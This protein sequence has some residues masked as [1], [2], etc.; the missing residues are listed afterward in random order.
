[1][2]QTFEE[3]SAESAF[4][5]GEEG[6]CELCGL[7]AELDSGR[8]EDCHE[9]LASGME[10]F[11]IAEAAWWAWADGYAGMMCPLY[12]AL[13]RSK[14]VPGYTTREPESDEAKR[15]YQ[16]LL[17][18]YAGVNPEEGASRLF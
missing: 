18:K 10:E 7:E 11:D 2:R 8:C 9:A 16:H 5:P 4:E 15:H 17:E 1:M 14:Y 6:Y 13:C 12:A 3:W